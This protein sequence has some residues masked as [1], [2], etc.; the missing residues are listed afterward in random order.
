VIVIR[1]PTFAKICAT[2]EGPEMLRQL[3]A[4]LLLSWLCVCVHS[5]GAYGNLQ[6]N[7][8]ALRHHRNLTLWLGWRLMMRT[9]AVLMMLHA[10]EIA[11]WAEFYLREHCFADAET[12]FYFSTVTYVTLGYGD[13]LLP[14]EWRI[15]GAAEAVIGV[16]MFGWSTA[17]LV[18]FVHHIFTSKLKDYFAE[19]PA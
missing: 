13:V 6:L 5:V 7:A 9:V 11:I 8:R 15:T 14:H 18:S 10:L 17:S 4:A 19:F 3:L 1:W 12:A 16:L 2:W